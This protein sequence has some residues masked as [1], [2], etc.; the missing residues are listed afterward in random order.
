MFTVHFV[1]QEQHDK[2]EK[3]HY[4][5]DHEEH[6]FDEVCKD[7]MKFNLNYSNVFAG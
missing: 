1:F 5:K 6:H 7:F 3:G 4:D 2:G